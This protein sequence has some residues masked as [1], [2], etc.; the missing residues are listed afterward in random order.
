M[1]F[2]KKLADKVDDFLEDKDKPKDHEKR[3]EHHG[4]QTRSYGGDSSYGGSHTPQYGS[5][6]GGPP[7]VSISV[8]PEITLGPFRSTSRVS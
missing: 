4:D 3:D 5:Q 7:Q 1:S 2:F 6:H 8:A